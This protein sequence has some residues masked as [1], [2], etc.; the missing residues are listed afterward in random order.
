VSGLLDSTRCPGE[1]GVS[2]SVVTKALWFK[3]PFTQGKWQL[4]N[5]E[6]D[7][8]ET[9]DLS[10]AHPQKLESLIQKWNEYAKRV[11]VLDFNGEPAKG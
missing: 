11:G 10:Q 1:S 6:K 2:S 8:G 5:I 3:T 4:F 9:K 7:P